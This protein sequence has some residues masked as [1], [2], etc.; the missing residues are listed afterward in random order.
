MGSCTQVYDTTCQ[1]Y[2]AR[3]KY[4]TEKYIKKWLEER[5]IEHFIPFRTVIVEYNGKKKKQERPLIPCIVFV[6]TTYQ[7]ALS[8]PVESGFSM[9]Y[10][11]N[12]DTRKI[13]VVPDKQ[14]QDCMFLLNMIDTPVLRISN[15]NLKRGDR[16]RVIR[17]PFMGVEG[18]L[19]RV[20]GHKRVIVRLEGLFSL[21]TT[22][23]PGEF[24]EKI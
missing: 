13:Q 21:V 16:V 2:A 5:G 15:V 24:L 23:I 18:E 7:S 9:T 11:R 1:W 12:N 10:I 3:V 22:Y 6:N 8:L 20:K 19:V 4:Q 17:G 14:M